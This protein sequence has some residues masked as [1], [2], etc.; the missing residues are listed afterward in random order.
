MSRASLGE[1][2]MNLS[3]VGGRPHA[4]TDAAWEH[5]RRELARDAVAALNWPPSW[6]AWGGHRRKKSATPETLGA[7]LA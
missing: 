7:G 2:G 6:A 5:H 3:L 1:R 4:R